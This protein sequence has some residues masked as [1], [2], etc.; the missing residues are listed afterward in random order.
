[1]QVKQRNTLRYYRSNNVCRCAS[2]SC[3][4]MRARHI[5][6][7]MCVCC[8]TRPELPYVRN[9]VYECVNIACSALA[10]LLRACVNVCT[11]RARRECSGLICLLCITDITGRVKNSVYC[12]NRSISLADHRRY[13]QP[14]FAPFMDVQQCKRVR[15][16]HLV[17]ICVQYQE[18]IHI[19][20]FK[21][22]VVC[23][24]LVSCFSM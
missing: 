23:V 8:K 13:L 2:H 5:S 3:L 22:Q 4:Q 7:G 16:L 24:G 9:S 1:M 17:I 14:I 20:N 12:C 21:Y 15:E 10:K 19:S 6:R 11:M 18:L